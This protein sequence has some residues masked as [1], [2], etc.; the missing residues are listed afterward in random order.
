MI[1]SSLIS[2]RLLSVPHSS[3]MS[4]KGLD[5]AIFYTNVATKTGGMGIESDHFQTDSK[6]YDK[7]IDVFLRQ[8]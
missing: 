2:T 6:A 4:R 8:F 5:L 3:A 1:G 7:R